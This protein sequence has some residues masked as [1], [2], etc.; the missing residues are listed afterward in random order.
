M[1][2]LWRGRLPLADA[3]WLHAI[4]GVGTLNLVCTFVRFL[5]IAEDGPAALAWLMFFLPLPYGI[6]A[7]VGVWRSSRHAGELV[8]AIARWSAAIWGATAF[9]F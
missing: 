7:L 8:G 9:V 4:I 3:F 5:V 1:I 2:A 6:A